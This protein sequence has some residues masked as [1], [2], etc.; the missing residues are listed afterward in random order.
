MGNVTPIKGNADLR[1]AAALDSSVIIDFFP[2][3][4]GRSQH[5]ECTITPVIVRWRSCHLNVLMILAY[6]I[7]A[8]EL[9]GVAFCQ[10]GLYFNGSKT[11]AIIT[12]YR[13]VSL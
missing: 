6:C 4:L 9:Y 11:V 13:H 2:T 7:V 10:I 1:L 12:A 3:S 8:S 5:V